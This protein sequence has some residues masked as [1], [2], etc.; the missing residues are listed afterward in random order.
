MHPWL[1]THYFTVCTNI[2][3]K[4]GGGILWVNMMHDV[5]VGIV[6]PPVTIVFQ[7]ICVLLLLHQLHY[8][9][10]LFTLASG[11]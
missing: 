11:R 6:T 8:V 3:G 9:I 2:G 10:L 5:I 1:I 7:Y 4:G